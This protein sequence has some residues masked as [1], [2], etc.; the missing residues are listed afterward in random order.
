MNQVLMC[1]KSDG[2]LNIEVLDERRKELVELGRSILSGDNHNIEEHVINALDAG[3]SHKDILEVVAYI[4][5][6]NLL[7]KSVIKLFRVLDYEENRRAPYI[8]VLDDIREEV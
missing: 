1:L 8:S 2:V 3:A 4:L 7:F 5:S 6:D